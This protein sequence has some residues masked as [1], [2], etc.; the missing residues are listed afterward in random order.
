MKILNTKDSQH[1]KVKAVIYGESG[2]GKTTLAST[3]GKGCLV[4][5]AEAGLLTLRDAGIDY[6]DISIDDAGNPITDPS[7]RLQRLSDVFKWLH[8]GCPD[9]KNKPTFAYTSIFV[10]GLTEIGELMVEVLNK[11]FP[12]R[13]D[14]FPMWGEYSKRMR[15]IVKSFRDLPYN[16][17]MTCV[18]E[19]D[20]DENKR[21][22]MGFQLSGSISKK[23]PQYFDEVFYLYV[24]GEGKRSLITNKTDALICKDRS[25]KLSS[26]EPAD[27]TLIMNKI[28]N[29]EDK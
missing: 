16:V 11:Q 8:A 26:M 22:F 3:I 6:V 20:V 15:S 14:S 4:V 2:A 17:F 13:K 19:S 10:D 29:K 1:Q 7:L 28:F 27:L 25:G 24:D 12:D 23:L 5:S 21:R 18:A 9:D